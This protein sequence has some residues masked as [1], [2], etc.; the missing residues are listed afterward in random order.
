MKAIEVK[1]TVNELGQLSLDEPLTLAKHSR[2]R[3]IVLIAEE[4][5]ED[6]EVA[7]SASE[8]FRQGWHDAMS[9]NIIP[10]SQL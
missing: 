3:V 6:E 4:N 9:G 10:I 1:G 5:E 2:V 7:E 8:S